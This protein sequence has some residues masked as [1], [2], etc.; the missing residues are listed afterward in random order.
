MKEKIIDVYWEGPFKWGELEKN[1]DGLCHVLYTIYGRHPVYGHE[2]LL[3]IGK[4]TNV[5][6]RMDTH[7]WWVEDE[8]DE[9]TVRAASMGEIQTWDGWVEN[10]RYGKPDSYML[11]GVEA[12][13]INAHQ[14]AYN[15]T[16]KDSMRSAEGL[17]VFN[18]G[19]IGSL[20]PEIS[21]RY[22]NSRG[23]W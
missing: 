17:R 4:T 18:T 12:L 2:S 16:S 10:E 11:A 21:Y 5:G 1:I 23:D 8:Y 20:L 15:Q 6:G 14:P 22:H 3:Y 7:A 13:L 9:I 19:R